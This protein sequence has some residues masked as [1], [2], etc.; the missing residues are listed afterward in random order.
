MVNK[1][2]VDCWNKEN[3][4]NKHRQDLIACFKKNI[5]ICYYCIRKNNC[6]LYSNIMGFCT[7]FQKEGE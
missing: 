5:S 4:T 1:I 6:H 3:C 7:S 2:C